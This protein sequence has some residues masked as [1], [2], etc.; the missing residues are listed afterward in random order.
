[1][2]LFKK[3]SYKE[4]ENFNEKNTYS[5]YVE[6]IKPESF[7]SFF[8]EVISDP[9]NI[10]LEVFK[11]TMFENIK[12]KLDTIFSKNIKNNL[13]YN[14]WLKDMEN[15][16]KIFCNILDEASISFSLETSRSCKR[17]HIDNV[18]MRLL[19]T[20]YGVGTE[21]FPSHACN[22]TAYY[23]GKPNEEIIIDFKEKK[24]FKPWDIAIFKG[25]KSK[26]GDKAILHRTPDD[27]LNRSSLLMRLDSSKYLSNI[28]I[29][30]I[31]NKNNYF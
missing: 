23:E 5:Y 12:N 4:L 25:Q 11:S 24:N 19:V 8:E 1:M 10:N 9:F 29:P 13:L 22:Y 14:L 20:Y 30:S 3:I 18:P 7:N 16:C 15:I 28:E 31:E 27:A 17:F 2:S 6:R 21:W 26:G